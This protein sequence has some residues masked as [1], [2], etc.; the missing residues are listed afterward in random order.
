[1]EKNLRLK[2]IF[3]LVIALIFQLCI[4]SFNNETIADSSS[5]AKWTLMMYFDGDNK[6]EAVMET[7]LELIRQINYDPNIQIIVLIDGNNVGDTM[8]YHVTENSLIEL[9]WAT[10][11]DM[12]DPTTLQQFIQTVKNEYISDYYGLFIGSNKGS[13]W[14][15]VCYD[16]HGDGTMITMPELDQVLKTVTNSGNSKLDIISIETCMGGNTAVAY[17]IKEYCSYYIAGPECGLVAPLQGIGFPYQQSISDLVS[18]PDMHPEEFSITCVNNFNPV[19]DPSTYIKTNL[20]AVNLSYMTSLGC[21]YSDLA[22]F[23]RGNIDVYKK[24]IKEALNKTKIFGEMWGINYIIEPYH[25]LEQLVIDN[26]EYQTFK[27][28]IKADIDSSVLAKKI[29]PGDIVYGLNLYLPR[30]TPDYNYALRYDSGILPSPYEETK[31]AKDTQWDEFLKTFLGIA[32][33]KAPEIPIITG[34]QK[35]K[36]GEIFDYNVSAVDPDGDNISFFIEWG[37]N[38]NS[39]WLGPFPS[40][41]TH[42]ESHS[43]NE[44]GKFTIQVKAKDIHEAESDWTS[45]SVSMPKTKYKENNKIFTFLLGKISDIEENQQ[46]GIQFLPLRLLK[47]IIGSEEGYSIQIIDATYGGYPCCTYIYPEDFHGIINSSFICG[48]WIT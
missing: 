5:N 22:T 36:T 27:N 19:Y 14:Q 29:Y 6:L 45:L 4:I 47:I 8:L 13:A 44:Q 20:V 33:N 11:S 46:G 26:T 3:C 41:E 24:D 31:F 30:N 7:Q 39:G 48:V 15:G 34:P 32:Y 37:D 9:Q 21:S 18:N 2:I 25:F 40:G 38:T 16:E 1:M 12:D 10:E 35:G 42:T 17:E 43:W 23:L 28:Q